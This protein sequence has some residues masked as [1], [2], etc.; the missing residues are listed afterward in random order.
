MKQVYRLILICLSFVCLSFITIK[1]E[2]GITKVTYKVKV[3]LED[4]PKTYKGFSEKKIKALKYLYS[5][6]SELDYTLI[7]DNT[8]GYFYL[9]NTPILESDIESKALNKI[10]KREKEK[11]CYYNRANNEVILSRMRGGERILVVDSLSKIKWDLTNESKKIGDFT[12]FKATIAKGKNLLAYDENLKIEAWY[13]PQIPIPFGPVQFEGLPGLIL[14]LKLGRNIYYASSV[15]YN[16][17]DSIIKPTKGKKIT[18]LEYSNNLN[19]FV[20][21][22]KRRVQTRN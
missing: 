17:N 12:C 7:F 8:E 20:K 18:R 3:N 5:K 19:E 6:R 16:Q 2:N 4:Y 21:D 15:K 1:K 11:T 22:L 13:T 14:E 10:I 9:N